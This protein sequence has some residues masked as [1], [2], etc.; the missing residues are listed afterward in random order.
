MST[1]VEGMQIREA[2]LKSITATAARNGKKPHHVFLN[3]A[4]PGYT[5]D[6]ALFIDPNSK[7]ARGPLPSSLNISNAFIRTLIEALDPA[8]KNWSNR[9]IH[10]FKN[11]FYDI[12]YPDY[13]GCFLQLIDLATDA[14][15][16]ILEEFPA[17]D[18][19]W[20]FNWSRE[21]FEYFSAELSALR[22]RQKVAFDTAYVNLPFV[23]L[24]ALE[25]LMRLDH[26]VETDWA[27]DALARFEAKITYPQSGPPSYNLN[28]TYQYA[29]VSGQGHASQRCLLLGFKLGNIIK[30]VDRQGR[31]AAAIALVAPKITTAHWKGNHA[32]SRPAGFSCL[33]NF[34]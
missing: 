4:A 14:I 33:L 29:K 3:A 2:P 18:P 27:A 6:H 9:R 23:S 34:V 12:N 32:T 24:I 5:F 17:D 16:E 28:V 1:L 30:G 22:A 7:G 31:P 8:E 15:F 21:K 13:V 11:S 25:M 19:E 20:P 26:W 10:V